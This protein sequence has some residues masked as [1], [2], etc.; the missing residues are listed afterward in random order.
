MENG[1]KLQNYQHLNKILELIEAQKLFNIP[2]NKLDILIHPNSLV[3]AIIKKKN[4][5]SL[6]MYHDTSMIIPLANAMFDEKLNIKEFYK[7]DKNKD[8]LEN[9]IFSKVD[10]NIF[11][12]I[13]LKDRANEYPSTSII[14]NAAN[15][16]LVE[17]FLKKKIPF[18]SISKTILKI[19]ND[20]NYK[21]Y[22]IRNPKNIHEITNIDKWTR[23]N[24]K[25][26][27]NLND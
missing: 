2:N 12:V 27:L 19:L 24:I 9:L 23:E 17:L 4:G 3:H 25:K 14:I 10:K 15:E 11:P 1:K 7:N 6:F 5:L 20:R 13:N 22:A 21:K 8:K 18:L 26:K 16:I